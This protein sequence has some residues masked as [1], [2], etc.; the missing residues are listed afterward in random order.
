MK[1]AGAGSSGKSQIEARA[2]LA[3][4]DERRVSGVFGGFVMA[5]IDASDNV[6]I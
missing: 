4:D 1:S 5:N 2:V 6:D 3:S